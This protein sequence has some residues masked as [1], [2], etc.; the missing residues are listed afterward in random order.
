[1][2]WKSCW[3]HQDISADWYGVIAKSKVPAACLPQFQWMAKL[4]FVCKLH[5]HV[6]FT[7][8][9]STSHVEQ[10]FSMLEIVKTKRGTSLHISNT[11]WSSWNQC[12]RS[13][14]QLI[15]ENVQPHTDWMRTQARLTNPQQ[16]T[17]SNQTEEESDKEESTL[18]LDDCDDWV[19]SD[20]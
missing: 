8:P 1:M 10:T 16:S 11:W 9:F 14:S 2:N 4:L 3:L 13:A 12:G 15:Q 6:N 7:F 17:T 20:Y 18:V 19:C 5:V